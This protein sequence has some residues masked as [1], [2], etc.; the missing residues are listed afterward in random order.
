SPLRMMYR[1]CLA[2]MALLMLTAAERTLAEPA[3]VLDRFDRMDG[4]SAVAGRGAQVSLV[5]G[6]GRQG[7]A[8][9]V[10]FDF[11]KGGGEIIVHKSFP[12]RLPE[13]YAITFAV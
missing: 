11:R 8:L 9:R 12:V 3:Q 5:S 7:Q 13:N 6:R 1:T 2:L 10:G 4:W